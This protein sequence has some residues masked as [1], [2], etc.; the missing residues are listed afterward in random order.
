MSGALRPGTLLAG[1]S[2]SLGVACGAPRPAA[3]VAVHADLAGAFARAFHVDAVGDPADAARSYEDLIATAARS[4]G[5][6]WQLPALEAALDALATRRMRALGEAAPYAAL[7]HRASG[8]DVESAL[9]RAVAAAR[10]P[11]ARGLVA[12]ALTSLAEARG[13]AASAEAQRALGGCAREATVVGP[14]SWAPVT[15]VEVPGPIERPDA[16]IEAGYAAGDALSSTSHPVVVR[17]HGCALPLAAESPRYGVRYVAVDVEVP[18]A[19]TVGVVLRAHGAAVLYAAGTP[20]LHRSFELGQGDAARMG[21]LSSTAGTLRLVVRV[22]M[23]RDDDYVE[24]DAFGDDGAPL[25]SHAPLEGSRANA[26]TGAP[27]VALETPAPRTEDEALLAAAAAMASGSPHE[28]ENLLWSAAG[29]ADLRPDLALV[30]GR[31]VEIAHDLSV[32]TRAERARSA[33]ERTLAVW[34]D[35]W[36]AMVAHAVLAGLRRGHDD[37]GIEALRDLDAQRAGAKSAGPRW[38]D[39]WIGAYDAITSARSQL[40]DR[41]RSALATAETVPG[42]LALSARDA[43]NPAVGKELSVRTCERTRPADHDTLACFDA[44]R[45]TGDRFAAAR[46]LERLRTTL[47]APDRFRSLELRELLAAGDVDHAR[48][49]FERML[50]AERTLSALAAVASGDKTT[51]DALVRAA[52]RAA[53]APS[54]IAPLLRAAGDDPAAAFD[55][56]A[57]Q[58]A[59][60]DRAHPILPNAATAVLAHTETYDL[61]PTGVLHWVLFD[62]RRVSGTTDVEENAQAPAPLIMGR[63]ALRAL[64]RRILKK[65][66]RVMEPE[67]TPHAAQEHADLSQLEQGDVVEAVYEGWALAGDTSQVGVDTPDLLPERVAVHDATI[68]VRLSSSLAVSM[69]SHPLLG[70]PTSKDDGVTCVRRWHVTDAPARR[71]EDA[72]PRVE[73]SASVSFT[74][75]TWADFGRALRETVAALDDHDPEIAA[76]AR[77]AIDLAQGSA[78]GRAIVEA[79]VHAAGKALHEADAGALSDYAQQI[80]PVATQTARTALTSHFGSR[81]WLVL[82]GL[83]ELG[84]PAEIVVAENEPFASDKVALVAGTSFPPHFGRFVHPLVVARVAGSDAGPPEEVWIDADVS[85]PPLPAGHISPELR[86]RLALRSDGTIAPLPAVGSAKDERDEVDIRLALD[87]GG[88]AH[89]SF[90][91]VLRGRTAQGLAESLVRIVGAERQRALRDVVLGWLPWANV[92]QVQL[93]SSEGSW[94]VSLRAQVTI[95]GYAQVQKGAAWILPGLDAI[96]V[97]WPNARVLSLASVFA[98]RAGRESAL[99]VSSAIQYH[100]HRR[101]E[102]PPGATPNRLPGP[103]DVKGGLVEASRRIAVSAAHDAE[104]AALEDDFVL[105]VSTGMVAPDAYE[106]FARAAHDVDDAF[107]ASTTLDMRGKAAV[108]PGGPAASP[109]K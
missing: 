103:L 43:T 95:G 32:G 33:Y 44:L 42:A 49:A 47:G 109:R 9:G 28:A 24:I 83:R 60:D 37:A 106:A 74:T 80:S 21:S 25:A 66:G 63:S 48:A 35:S 91:V 11:F 75:A 86:G 8:L 13:D 77:G 92:D 55:G 2:L 76:W 36:E 38:H 39:A 12:R 7:A 10:G 70:A 79:V 17:G 34:P 102:L 27:V 104:P 30:Y 105:G 54:A 4:E 1:L 51:R 71:V 61:S 58:I 67:Q 85:G 98:E 69:W 53:D 45:S 107:L 16:R 3:P 96:H 90:A 78:S 97:V 82:R 81:S 22:G 84:I 14:V 5:D 50:P 108:A 89:G 26:R 31:A 19:E 59:A 29:R 57:D 15:G 23:A 62:V 56:R 68:E 65:D 87:D 88:D 101:V 64:R 6:P 20:V 99:A 41:A 72:I 46:E 52:A 40:F 93:S 73:R 18:R 100:V 94:Q